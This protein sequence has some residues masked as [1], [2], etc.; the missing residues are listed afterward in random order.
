MRQKKE[1]WRLYPFESRKSQKQPVELKPELNIGDKVLLSG[2]QD[3]TRKILKIE[4]HYH[5]HEFVYI[6]ETSAVRFEPY[7][8]RKQLLKV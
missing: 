7:W 2:K 8:F 6:I 5:R 4:W 1:W 3:I